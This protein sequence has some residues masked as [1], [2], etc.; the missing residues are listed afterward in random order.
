MA[1]D[2]I[3]TLASL[4][5]KV[6]NQFDADAEAKKVRK[7]N[8]AYTFEVASRLRNTFEHRAKIDQDNFHKRLRKEIFRIDVENGEKIEWCLPV[9]N[10]EIHLHEVAE[11]INSLKDY[12]WLSIYLISDFETTFFSDIK[13][14]VSISEAEFTAIEFHENFMSYFSKLKF[15][16]ERPL[17]QGIERLHGRHPMNDWRVGIG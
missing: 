13:N 5:S 10:P 12:D 1:S 7:L 4:S 2:T 3:V 11:L 14:V 15:E 6:F 9:N 16:F 8:I 17:D